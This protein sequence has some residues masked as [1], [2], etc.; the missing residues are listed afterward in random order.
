MIKYIQLS[1]VRIIFKTVK[2]KC[3]HYLNLKSTI[4]L[5]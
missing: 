3:I 2:D 1:Q 4:K 5:I